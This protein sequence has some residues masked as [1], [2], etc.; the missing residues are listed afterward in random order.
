MDTACEE[1]PDS[2]NML[3]SM[4]KEE[5]QEEKDGCSKTKGIVELLSGMGGCQE[6]DSHQRGH[7]ECVEKDKSAAKMERV[8]RNFYKKFNPDG[9]GKGKFYHEK[10]G[11][12]IYD[13]FR[14]SIYDLFK[15]IL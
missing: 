7:C 12:S 13:L 10:I 3:D 4:S 15:R 2:A 8:L 6:F 1:L 5:I 11:P 9:V 14:P